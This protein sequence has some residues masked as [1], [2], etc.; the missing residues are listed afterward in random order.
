MYDL[1]KIIII[2]DFDLEEETELECIVMQTDGM[3][4]ENLLYINKIGFVG[5]DKD[6]VIESIKSELYSDSYDKSLKIKYKEAYNGEDAM[7][8]AAKFIS[9]KWNEDTSIYFYNPEPDCFEKLR[10][11]LLNIDK[12]IYL[13]NYKDIFVDEDNK[14]QD[15]YEIM[16]RHQLKTQNLIKDNNIS[17]IYFLSGLV[18]KLFSR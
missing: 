17:M 1:R 8:I 18:E 12:D 4:I 5:C 11:N 6:E 7:R 9:K 3:K 15:I 16:E 13:E 2:A 10:K 14:N